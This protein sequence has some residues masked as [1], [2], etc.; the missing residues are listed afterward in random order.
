VPWL[1]GSLL[2]ASGFTTLWTLVISFAAEPRWPILAA[3]AVAIAIG[4]TLGRRRFGT[5]ARADTIDS[6]GVAWT[7]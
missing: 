3:L 2:F 1:G 6:E 7:R 4:L 5:G